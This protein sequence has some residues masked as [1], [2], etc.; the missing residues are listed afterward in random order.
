[1]QHESSF[2]IAVYAVYGVVSVGLTFWLARTLS[3]NGEAFLADVFEDREHLGQSLNRLLVVGFYMLNLGYAFLILQ[4]NYAPTALDAVELLVSKL[5]LL[6]VS[7]GIIHFVNMALF[8]KIRSRTS[9]RGV[10]VVAQ[11]YVNPGMAGPEMEEARRW[12][13]PGA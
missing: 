5:G 3:R 13:P 8:W 12:P 9:D 11:A 10:P 6:L 4:S 2:V 1:M 7:L